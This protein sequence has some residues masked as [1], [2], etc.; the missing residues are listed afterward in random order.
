MR[1]GGSGWLEEGERWDEVLPEIAAT[2]VAMHASVLHRSPFEEV[3]LSAA[4]RHRG[5][6]D[7]MV[8]ITE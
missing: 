3:R 2:I 1:G 6:E 8:D 7:A 4:R 5:L